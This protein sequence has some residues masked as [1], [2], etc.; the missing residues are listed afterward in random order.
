MVRKIIRINEEKC[1]GCSLCVHAC[2]EG[3]I[4]IVDEK[5]RLIRDDYCDGLGNCLPICPVGAIGFEE[6]E[7]AAFNEDAVKA[8]QCQ[9]STQPLLR[10]QPGLGHPLPCGCPGTHSRE[11]SRVPE[12]AAP[13]QCPASDPCCAP[14]AT[15]LRQWPVQIKLVPINALYFQNARLLI[16]ADCA[17]Y[18]FG[19]FHRRFMKDRVTLIGCPKLD[20][21]DYSGKLTEIIATNDIKSVLVARMEVPCCAGIENAVISAMQN[22]G[23]YVPWQL[24]TMTI[25]GDFFET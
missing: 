13:G 6:R 2:H 16:A 21:I 11:I 3:A 8:G 22:S 25:D 5:A 19:D 23:K 1:N 10:P 15:E 7:A 17:A 9:N 14:T 18:A 24:V 4:A 12:Q 20:N